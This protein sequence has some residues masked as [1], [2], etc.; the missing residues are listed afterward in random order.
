MRIFFRLNLLCMDFPFLAISFH[1]PLQDPV[2]VF[3]IVLF[4]IL[5]APLLMKKLRIPGI[6]GLILAGIVLGHHGFNILEGDLLQKGNSINLFGTVGLLYIMF[7]AG[8]ELNLN[9][10]KKNQHKSILFGIFTFVFP[11]VIGFLIC[12]HVLHLSLISSILVA[13]MFS[14]H[15]LVAYP[16][17]S[18]LRIISNE[19]VAIAVGATIITDTLVL[20]IL[21]VITGY[22]EGNI[23]ASFWLKLGAAIVL[24]VAL[25]FLSFPPIGRWFFRHVPDDE[26]SHFMFVLGMV[27]LAGFMAEV[28]GVEAIIG[29][30]MAGLALNRLI[31]HTSPLMNRLEFVG[32]ALFIPFFLI[33]VGMLVDVHILFQGWE[34]WLVAIVLT[35]SAFAGKFLAAFLAQKIFHYDASQRGVIFGLTSAHA[36][37]TLAVILT[38]YKVGLVDEQILNGTIVLIL[39]TCLVA[40][41]ATETSGKKLAISE[42]QKTPE[43]EEDRDVVMVAISNP[44]T[45]ER[46]LDFALMLKASDREHPVFALS[47]IKDNE[48]ASDEVLIRNR[49]L[50][51]AVRRAA[52]T[53][54]KVQVVTRIDLNT[55]SGIARA[56]KELM[57]TDLVLGWSSRK[58]TL[59]WIFGNTLGSLVQEV[60][61]SVYLCNFALPLNTARKI[62]VIVPRN[63]EYEIGFQQWVMKLKRISHEIGANPLIYCAQSSIPPL[64]NLLEN[65]KPVVKPGF[66]LF[67]DMEDFLIAARD[68]GRDDWLWVVSA[69]KGTLSHQPAMDHLGDKLNKHFMEQNFLLLYPGQRIFEEHELAM[70]M[71]DLYAGGLPQPIES[72]ERLTRRMRKLIKRKPGSNLK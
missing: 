32:N 30:F 54:H 40:S 39:F 70:R 62:V 19:A 48:K 66:V 36:A 44:Q 61:Q 15:T 2:L 67:E 3:C 38:G 27:F 28:A 20:L 47:V 33:G 21:A 17:A 72:L 68:V 34:S 14:T 1:L 63:A 55:V 37:A 16:I 56:T 10:F 46:L 18:R 52:A 71:N 41:F 43:R 31:P 13:S 12:E 9:E 60:W 29:A 8:L 35:A 42:I 45:I 50:E 64:L 57:V 58:R 7:L 5:L 26:I 23:T 53:N 11:F 51:E 22:A 69:R 6:I 25:I 24:F 49:M 59:E 4:V 65:T